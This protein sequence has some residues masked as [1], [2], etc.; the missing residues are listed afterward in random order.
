MRELEAA[1][2]EL[3]ESREQITPTSLCYKGISGLWLYVF[4]LY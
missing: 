2:P 1:A 4:G 3:E